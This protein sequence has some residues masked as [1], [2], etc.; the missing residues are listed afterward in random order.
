MGRRLHPRGPLPRHRQPGRHRLRPAPGKTRGDVPGARSSA[1]VFADRRRKCRGDRCN[2]P[3]TRVAA[4]CAAWARGGIA[5]RADFRTSTSTNSKRI[6]D[7]DKFLGGCENPREEAMSRGQACHQTK[8]SS[9]ASSNLESSMLQQHP[10]IMPGACYSRRCPMRLN[11][12][13]LW[14]DNLMRSRRL[15]S[16]SAIN[17]IQ[18]NRAWATIVLISS[19]RTG[20]RGRSGWVEVGGT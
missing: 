10:K 13:P 17:C 5:G 9:R 15:G 19:T 2:R 7:D 18:R 3:R 6:I 14:Q 16:R 11:F 4:K 12:R 8:T 20:P 1:V